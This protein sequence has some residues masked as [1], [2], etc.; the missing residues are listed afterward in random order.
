MSMS[1]NNE[2][3]EKQIKTRPW[4]EDNKIELIKLYPYKTNKERGNA[5]G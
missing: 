5:Y 1:K 2:Q 3:N 4:T